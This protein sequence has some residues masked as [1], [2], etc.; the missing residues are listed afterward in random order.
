MN[1][2]QFSEAEEQAFAEQEEA[3]LAEL[4]DEERADHAAFITEEQELDLHRRERGDGL[5][6]DEAGLVGMPTA[7]EIAEIASYYGVAI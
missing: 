7:E 3:T 1:D 4:T 2:M 6:L 5:E